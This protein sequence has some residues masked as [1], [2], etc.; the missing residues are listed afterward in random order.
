MLI[1][2]NI[3]LLYKYFFEGRVNFNA[4]SDRLDVTIILRFLINSTKQ[5]V[6]LIFIALLFN[7]CKTN[8]TQQTLFTKLDPSNTHISF[9]NDLSYDHK[10]NVY[11]YRN[12]YNGGGVAI[13]DINN[14]GLPDIFFTANMLP[15]RLYL[16][17]GNFQFEDIT[18]KAGIGKKGK[19][20]TGVSMADVNG[21]GSAGYLCL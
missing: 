8:S 18:D 15:N 20:S 9:S 14:D 13:G 4:W 3:Q 5:F 7:A 19:W 21:D 11:T 10:F 1:K 2:Q 12:F 17:K 16:N 6:A